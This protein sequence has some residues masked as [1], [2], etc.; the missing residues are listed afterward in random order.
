MKNATLIVP[1]DVFAADD[2]TPPASVVFVDTQGFFGI[3]AGGHRYAVKLDAALAEGLAEALQVIAAR[4]TEAEAE[5]ARAAATEA[6]M[7]LD[8]IVRGARQ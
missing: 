4:L 8:G 7:A 6:A 5:D 2:Q 1:G 3:A